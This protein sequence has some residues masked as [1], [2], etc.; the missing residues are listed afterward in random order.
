M[1][2]RVKSWLFDRCYLCRKPTRCR[3]SQCGRR[4]CLAHC[5]EQAV[6]INQLVC[7]ECY[8]DIVLEEI[9]KP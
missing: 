9:R 6:R 3:C 2:K 8:L 4:T 5:A 7:D 1:F